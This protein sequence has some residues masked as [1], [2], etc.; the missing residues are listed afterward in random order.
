MP[1]RIFKR[2]EA[3]AILNG[4]RKWVYL[5]ILVGWKA[6]TTDIAMYVCAPTSAVIGYFNVDA[7][8]EGTPDEIWELTKDEA[9]ITKRG[10]M[11]EFRR[12]SFMYAL[13]VGCRYT[14][15]PPVSRAELLAPRPKAMRNSRL[16]EMNKFV[17]RAKIV[18]D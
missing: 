9:D 6:E 18:I 4:R 13:K 8:L 12:A 10:F 7:L 2:S 17:D 11:R 16:G 14:I 3:D 5:S 1:I 15:T